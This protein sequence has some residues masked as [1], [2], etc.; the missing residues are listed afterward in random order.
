M[1]S[2]KNTTVVIILVVGTILL[3]NY[4][5]TRFFMRVDF[6][7]DNRYT[8]S[9]AT[10]NI[11]RD[12]KE[13]VTVTAYF[14]GN[15]PPQLEQVKRELRDMLIEYANYSKGMIAYEFVDPMKDDKI[16]SKAQ[17]AG[18][19]QMQVQVREKDQ[20]KAQIAYMGAVL[21]YKDQTEV[22]HSIQSTNGLEYTLSSTLKKMVVTN[23]PS[24]GLVQGHGEANFGKLW[25]AKQSLDILYQT[26][27][28]NLSDSSIQLKKYKTLMIVGPVDSIPLNQLVRLDQF[29]ENGGRIFVA[30]NR[31]KADLQQNQVTSAVNTRLETWLSQKGIDVNSNLVIDE[32]CARVGVQL[33]PGSYMPVSFPYFVRV[34]NFGKHPISSGLEAVYLQLTSSINFSGDSSIKFTP[35]LFSSEHTGTRPAAGFLDVMQ[36]WS[37]TDFPLSK[38]T[39]GAVVEGR[40][41]KGKP[42]KMVVIG[43]ADFPL[44]EDQQNQVNPDNIN[45][46]VNSIDWLSD[47]TGLVQLRTEGAT[48]RPIKEMTDTK[49]AIIKYLNFL[50]P[51]LLAMVYG[52]VRFQRNRIIRLKREKAGYV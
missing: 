16:Q 21:N 45:L 46:F 4:L 19:T 20:I 5:T 27:L 36:K 2:K 39:L 38:L 49:R 11:L 41:G 18:V 8:L 13:P 44:S 22:L 42:S 6:T 26:E 9:K 1:K 29:L 12:L 17:Q 25:Q 14:S 35:I 28:V 7:E 3:V 15:L 23:K 34:S 24:I 37:D 48:E 47:D 32:N 10:K 33:Q 52:I 50:L 43:D 30:I 40:F 31:A 51:I